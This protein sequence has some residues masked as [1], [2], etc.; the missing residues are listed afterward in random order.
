[1]NAVTKIDIAID[2]A[3]ERELQKAHVDLMRH[4]ST[5]AFAGVILRGKNE[6]VY[7]GSVPT[8]CTDGKN[9]RY[10]YEFFKAL[11]LP[12]KRGVVMHENFHDALM[13]MTRD[14]DLRKESARLYNVAAD[15]ALNA[16]IMDI[17]SKHPAFIT[18]PKG[19]MYNPMFNGWSARQVYL[20]L[21]DQC[22]SEPQ[23]QDGDGEG[24]GEPHAGATE[25]TDKKTGAKH[26]IGA[27]MDE[28]DYGRGDGLS[29]DEAADEEKEVREA[30]QQGGIVAGMRGAT[31]PRA[32]E[33]ALLPK[34]DWREMLRDFVSEVC[35]G[36]DELTWRQYDRRRM[37]C[38][39]YVPSTESETVGELVLA[40][41][42][43]G[44]ISQ[45]D[46]AAVASEVSKLCEEVEPSALRVVWWDTA[47]HGEQRFEPGDYS[48]IAHLLKPKG[49]G[50]TRV[51]CVSEYLSKLGSKPEAVIVFT[52]GYV[53]H[54]FT[55]NVGCPTLWI[56]PERGGNSTFTPPTGKVASM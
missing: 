51:G 2:H 52:D 24:S 22:E 27:P 53:E 44:S 26:N 20:Y 48:G 11:T 54:N 42:T 1:M 15:Y 6:V 23:P 34:V 46:L 16:I 14:R 9:K 28:H 10:G 17:A 37:A 35:K 40:I 45:D 12:E 31:L 39:M 55:W 5:C 19:C 4:S 13:H 38:D 7:D 18:L 3:V 21:R 56:L 33:D 43:S 25:V 36:R 47:V 41:D 8:A 49:G 32:I 50:G 30:L 29:D